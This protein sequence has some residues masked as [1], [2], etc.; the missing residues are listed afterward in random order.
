MVGMA[1]GMT[2]RR[3]TALAA[4]VLLAACGRPSDPAAERA[5][6]INAAIAA[7]YAPFTQSPEDAP[8]PYD[9]PIYS[10][11]TETL[12]QRWQAHRDADE[13]DAV[14]EADFLCE[15]QD[16]DPA[17]FRASVIK[18]ASLDFTHATATLDV[19]LTRTQIQKIALRLVKQGNAWKLDD[20]IGIDGITGR[21]DDGLKMTLR[22]TISAQASPAHR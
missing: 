14:S 9:R 10:A 22:K 15:C 18:L 12:I 2:P 11:E 13:V 19:R 5:A 7:I 16:W 20:I 4:L 17:V 3:L 8:D 21:P 1:A 6:A